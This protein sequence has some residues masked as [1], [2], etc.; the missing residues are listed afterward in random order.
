MIDCMGKS[1]AGLLINK[2]SPLKATYSIPFLSIH[3]HAQAC[4]GLK[5]DTKYVYICI[6]TRA[7]IHTY[8]YK[9]RV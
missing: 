5:A 8:L 7:H 9:R 1:L 3:I 6:H 4:G 2:Y